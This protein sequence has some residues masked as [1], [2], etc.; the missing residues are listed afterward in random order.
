[1]KRLRL[2]IDNEWK[3]SENGETFI[4]VDPSKNEPIAELALATKEDV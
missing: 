3:D 4:S 1:M 2:F